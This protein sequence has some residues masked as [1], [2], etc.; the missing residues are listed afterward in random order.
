M[1]IKNCHNLAK[2]R[3]FKG[4]TTNNKNNSSLLIPKQAVKA[5]KIQAL[6]LYRKCQLNRLTR[7]LKSKKSY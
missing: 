5:S 6:E 1:V 4:L 7:H 3:L 2:S